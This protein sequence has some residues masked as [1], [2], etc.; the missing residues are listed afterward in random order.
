MDGGRQPLYKR[1]RDATARHVHHVRVL[2]AF[3]KIRF[4]ASTRRRLTRITRL[5]KYRRVSSL[6]PLPIPAHCSL[7]SALAS[8]TTTFPTNYLCLLSMAPKPASTAGKAPAS[9]AS[10]A[11]AKTASEGA[12]KAA[13]KTAKASSGAGGDGDKKK[14]KK[15]RKE[16]YSSYIYKG[17]LC[18]ER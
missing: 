10:K 16:T 11:P 3:N 14:R 6:L 15:S 4:S 2:M 1:G 17:A 5:H 12:S 9:T 7:A 13:K 18:L 8:S